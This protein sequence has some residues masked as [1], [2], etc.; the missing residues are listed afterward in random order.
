MAE[1][2]LDGGFWGERQ[3]LNGDVILRARARLDR[4]HG[5]ARELPRRGRGRMPGD[6]RGPLFADSD[7]Y[8]LAEGLAWEVGRA[9][10]AE[11]D[12]A[13]G[14]IAAAAAGA[15]EP[16]GYLNTRYGPGR[17]P[18]TATSSGATSCTPTAT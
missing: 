12:A 13:I 10:D 9:G 4:A 11:L 7:V 2:Q 15:Q 5:L 6:F 8:K 17:T 3:Q 1:V 14:E 18:A 16:D